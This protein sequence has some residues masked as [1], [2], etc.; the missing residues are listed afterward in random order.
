MH[1]FL[2]LLVVDDPMAT[3]GVMTLRGL[4]IALRELAHH[5][6]RCQPIFAAAYD[7]DRT[8]D[9]GRIDC[10]GARKIQWPHAALESRTPRLVDQVSVKR[11]MATFPNAIA[12]ETPPVR[13]PGVAGLSPKPAN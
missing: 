5:A 2:C 12:G 9:L 11:E 3:L 1:H 10:G 7:V 13:K 8:P 4:R 6:G